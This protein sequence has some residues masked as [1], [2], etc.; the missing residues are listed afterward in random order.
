MTLATVAFKTEFAVDMTC[1]SCVDAVQGALRDIPGIERYDIDLQGKRVTITGK[2]PPSHLL[3][4]LKSTNRQVIVRGSSSASPNIPSTAA[5]SILESPLPLPLTMAST[6]NPIL[7]NSPSASGVSDKPLP[8]MNEEE[9]TQKVFGI[10]RFVQIAPKTVLMDLTVRLP[11]P[12]R[13]GLSNGAEGSQGQGNAAWNVYIASTGNM[14]NPPSTT[15]KPFFSLGSITPD[16]DGYGDMFKE[17]DGELWEWV[18]RG[19][20]VEAAATSAVSQPQDQSAIGRIFAG[21]VARS[22]GAWGNEKTVCACSGRTMWEEGRDMEKK[23]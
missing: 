11:P 9:H 23:L 12:A 14:V 19:C 10:C 22:A 13:I 18:G 16:K 4:A 15:G 6:S 17:V 2:T 8:G 1:Q 5:I 7:A 3:S 20:V 21:V